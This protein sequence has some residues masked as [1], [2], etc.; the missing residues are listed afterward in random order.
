MK[1]YSFTLLEV[2]IYVFVLSFIWIYVVMAIKQYYVQLWKTN[3]YKRF[4]L[5]YDDMIKMIYSNKYNWWNLTWNS[6]S[7]LV[8]YN[9][10][11]NSNVKWYLAYSCQKWYLWVTNVYTWA[12]QIDWN[13][14]HKMFSWVNCNA[15]TGWTTAKW[16]WVSFD[17]EILN[18][19]INTRY[20]IHKE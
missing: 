13:I 19:K 2:V 10:W 17:I 4:S 6:N 16:Y 15:L 14:F 18:K 12:S 20:Y 5:V 9:S 11:Y 7:W 8:L 1:K 3:S